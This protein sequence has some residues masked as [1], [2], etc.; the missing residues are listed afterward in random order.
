M[1]SE[2][3]GNRDAVTITTFSPYGHVVGQLDN[4][5]PRELRELLDRRAE[6]SAPLVIGFNIKVYGCDG[7]VTIARR[8]LKNAESVSVSNVAEIRERLDRIIKGA[9]L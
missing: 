1:R 2:V 9:V 6:T 8:S 7:S 4:V 3:T 5:N